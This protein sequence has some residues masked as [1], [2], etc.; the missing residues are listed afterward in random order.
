MAIRGDP[1]PRPQNGWKKEHH[2]VQN[3][4]FDCRHGQQY[5]PVLFLLSCYCKNISLRCEIAFSSLPISR[6]RTALC[7][8]YLG[9]T[10]PTV[11]GVFFA[12]VIARPVIHLMGI[13]SITDVFHDSTASFLTPLQPLRCPSLVTVPFQY[14]LHPCFTSHCSLHKD[15]FSFIFFYWLFL[16]SF[17]FVRFQHERVVLAEWNISHSAHPDSG[18]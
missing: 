2:I 15:I 3:N 14:Y 8:Q 17:R 13:L 18:K 12:V 1:F 4:N 6:N 9:G 16:F 7:S 5:F 10:L 11:S